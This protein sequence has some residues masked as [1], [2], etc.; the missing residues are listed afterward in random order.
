M[1]T[2]VLS[3]QF[4]NCALN[5]MQETEINIENMET[6]TA[7]SAAALHERLVAYVHA[8]AGGPES[9]SEVWV[10][11]S[12]ARARSGSTAGGEARELLAPRPPRDCEL[13]VERLSP[14][15]PA[16]LEPEIDDYGGDSDDDD[17]E[18]R[19]AAIAPG[20]AHARLVAAAADA[21]R[22]MRLARLAGCGAGA[23]R[24]AARRM[25]L[26]L[27]PLWVWPGPPQQRPPAWLHAVLLAYLPPARRRDYDDIIAQLR[28]LVPRLSERLLL[29]RVPPPAVDP[30]AVVGPA[31]PD[32]GPLVAWLSCGGDARWRRRLRALVSLRELRAPPGAGCP[33]RAV[34]SV[35]A[36]L[37][38]QLADLIAEA[39]SRPVVVGGAG[40]GA[41]LAAALGGARAKLLVAAPL[42]TAEGAARVAGGRALL[43]VG[44]AAA[45]GGRPPA[46]AAG[47]AGVRALLVAGADD[48]LRLPGRLRRRMRLPQH[49]LDAAIADECARWVHEIAEEEETSQDPSRV[50]TSELTYFKLSIRAED[51]SPERIER[52]E[53][54]RTTGGNRSIEIVEGRVV[55]RVCGS[56]PL[57][58]A[59]PRRRLPLAAADILQLPIV[60]ADDDPTPANPVPPAPPVAPVSP[61]PPAP[62]AVTVT[63]GRPRFARVILAKRGRPRRPMLLRDQ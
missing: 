61:A 44:G 9:R 16:P 31:A 45:R 58:L 1:G 29:G 26:A 46:G 52:T 32:T 2:E 56:R 39:G 55:S 8:L 53:R 60:F 41:A 15:P 62:P 38:G 37:R 33:Q 17:W 51:V 6:D 23:A 30:L 36:C 50:N 12:Y 40:A 34:A 42:R 27:A 13:D 35:A 21:L 10:E 24:D 47:A 43:V 25:R 7:E 48:Q 11:H 5:N 22:D 20:P 4:D 57:P 19:M 3:R 14:P 59:P 63:S 18:S 54:E 49:A 28:Y